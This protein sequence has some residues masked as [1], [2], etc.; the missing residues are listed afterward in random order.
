MPVR[1]GS[2]AGRT[3]IAT[4]LVIAMVIALVVL[5]VVRNYETSVITAVVSAVTLAAVEIVRSFREP[6][7]PPGDTMATKEGDEVDD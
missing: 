4:F 6:P 7:R 3:E 5:M 2:R 1:R